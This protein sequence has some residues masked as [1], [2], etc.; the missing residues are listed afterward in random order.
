MS[1]EAEATDVLVRIS[2]QGVEYFLKIAGSAT[3]RGLALL[4]AVIKTIYEKTKGKQKLG[5]KVNARSFL[6]NFISSSVFSVSKEDMKKLEPELK[7]LHIPYMRYKST[8]E[9]KSDGKIEISVRQEDAERFIR[10]AESKGIAALAAYDFKCEEISENT[11]E[12]LLNE[13]AARGVDFYVSPDGEVQI[14]ERKNPTPAPTENRSNPSEPNSKE[15]NSDNFTFDPKKGIDK[16]LAAA[17]VEAMRRD[18]RLVPISANKDTLLIENAKDGVI[19]TIPGTQ[20]KE[21]IFVPKGDIV[22]MNADG[23]LTIRA[24]LQAD[25]SY[26]ILDTN[27]QPVRN[28]TGK[29]IRQ[30][31]KWNRVSR[32]RPVQR[33]A[34]PVTRGRGGR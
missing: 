9:M 21:R 30:S 20:Q 27:N 17:K 24:D 15:S 6:T 13:G 12:E 5:G 11:Y 33:S 34:R 25:K 16:N 2:L 29:E 18:G 26:H 4:F 14:N 19:L 3:E 32:E 10:L 31:G 22:N 1:A 8:K 28:M 23:G 7:R